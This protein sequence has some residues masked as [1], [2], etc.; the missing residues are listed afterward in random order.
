M[1]WGGLHVC[2]WVVWDADIQ[3]FSQPFLSH[4]VCAA[5]GLL[6]CRC[7]LWL[8]FVAGQ[9]VPGVVSGFDATLAQALKLLPFSQD[10]S[11][12]VLSVSSAM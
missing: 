11:S 9:A 12:P 3:C 10:L 1:T 4:P 2:L 5:I 6:H 7:G 8:H